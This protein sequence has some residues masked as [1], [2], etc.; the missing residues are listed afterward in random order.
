MLQ[1]FALIIIKT[2]S[3]SINLY[4]NTIHVPL[5]N[6]IFALSFTRGLFLDVM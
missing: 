2:F 3:I 1:D 5:G 6:S 4:R